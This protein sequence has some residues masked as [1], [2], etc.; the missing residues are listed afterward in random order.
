[1]TNEKKTIDIGSDAFIRDREQVV[2]QRPSG[3][4]LTLYVRR[5]GYL[6]ATDL[7]AKVKA[8]GNTGLIELVAAAVEDEDGNRFTPEEVAL[9]RREIVQPLVKAVMDV[10]KLTTDD[11][12][13][14]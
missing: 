3:D 4:N 11:P 14:N 5:L 6:E 12:A 8:N 1:M 13:G 2:V 9:L 10:N 7:W